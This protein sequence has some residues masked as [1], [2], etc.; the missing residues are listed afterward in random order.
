MKYLL[1]N[2]QMRAADMATQR[3]GVSGETLMKR[4]G[5]ALAYEVM[6]A[7]DLV[8]RSRDVLF[9][10]GTGNNGGDGYVAARL[11]MERGYNV[12]V[13]ALEGDPSSD[14]AR[15][16]ER[17]KGPY[18]RRFDV[19]KV[20]VDCIFG[21]GLSREVLDHYRYAIEAINHSGAY[22]VS[23]DIPSGL[24]GDN[25]M[26][27][28]VAVKAD[29]T[30]CIAGLKLGYYLH[31]GLDLCGEIAFKDIGI[32][33]TEFTALLAENSDVA[34][35]FL[36]RPRNNHKGNF[37]TACIWGG[38]SYPGAATLAFS[39]A[40]M[41]GVGY[42]KFALE[43]RSPD[44][45]APAYPQIIYTKEPDMNAQA[46][47]FGMGTGVSDKTK[48]ELKYLLS[49]YTGKLIIDADG[50]KMIAEMGL[51]ILKDTKAKILLTPHLQEFSTLSGHSIDE[52]RSNPTKI[53][54]GFARMCGVSVIL[55]SS[56]AVISNG[57]RTIICSRGDSALAKAGS[58]DML[59]GYICG[60]AARGLDLVDAA[61]CAHYLFGVAAEFAAQEFTAYCCTSKDLM[62]NIPKAI[63]SLFEGKRKS[64]TL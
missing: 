57:Q 31:D 37:G 61:M 11:M 51:D 15:E 8:M 42:V 46:L 5:E 25:G 55:K 6:A 34:K 41:T 56:S 9:V 58:G 32:E 29:R 21:T 20:I 14:N 59:A 43:D 53:V 52:I 17:Y 27:L 40:M 24:N 49:N 22:V 54:Y 62:N 18:V 50:V 23:C 28:G 36:Q 16:K 38:Q 35:F 13:Y 4:G 3:K 2:D 30:V 44:A 47:A 7:C 12:S 60:L 10:C 64:L 19:A 26:A 45:Y 63:K 33:L 48:D 39:A 1:R